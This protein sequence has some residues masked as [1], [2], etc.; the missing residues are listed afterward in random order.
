MEKAGRELSIYIHIPFCVQKCLYCDFLSAPASMEVREQ[1]V[2]RV[3]REIRE[4]AKSYVNYKAKSVFFGGGTPSLL[5]GDQIEEI[6]D[7]VHSF[8]LEKDC[9]ISLEANPGTITPEKL[10]KYKKAG[11]NRLSIGLQSLIDEELRAL[12]RIH[13]SRDFYDTYECAVKTG[14]NNI[15]IDLM[16]AIP[17]QT[18]ESCMTTLRGVLELDPAPVHIS[19][20]SLIVEEGTPFFENTPLLPDEETDREL[21]KI[22]NDILNKS[23][24]QRYEI[25]NYAKPGFACRHNLVYW[26][27]GNYLGF[28]IGAASLMENV[29]FS[30][31]RGL[32]EYLEKGA[33][34]ENIQRLSV[35]EQM[36]EFMFLGLRMTEGVSTAKFQSSF[37]QSL[38]QVYPGIV[39]K[40]IRQGLLKTETCLNGRDER[41]S[42]TER[43]IDVSNVVMADFL[44][45]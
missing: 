29:R 28:G 32:K 38:Y 40:Y 34:R 2:K 8:S 7:A 9:E 14:F 20:Y 16:T 35:K 24:Y 36:E 26:Q 3:S 11:I 10:Q 23:G 45:M 31:G 25:S 1:Y 43:G 39:E 15:N 27:R 37:G 30:N 42:L 4:T 21:Y 17:L 12:G 44:F 18:R 22:T 33:V 19:A 5:E 41:I 13:D 6:M